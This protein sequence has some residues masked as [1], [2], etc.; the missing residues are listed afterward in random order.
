M[1]DVDNST[2]DDGGILESWGTRGAS[3]TAYPGQQ[4]LGGQVTVEFERGSEDVQVAVTIRSSDLVDGQVHHVEETFDWPA[5]SFATFVCALVGAQ[6]I[7]TANGVFA[8]H[9]PAGAV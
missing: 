1:S 2:P 8:P 9:G 3:C 7:A 4:G 5:A 6:A